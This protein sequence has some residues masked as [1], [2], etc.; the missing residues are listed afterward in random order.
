MEEEEWRQPSHSRAWPAGLS[1][2]SLVGGTGGLTG[3]LVAGWRVVGVALVVEV[4]PGGGGATSGG[5]PSL[6][7]GEEEAG[8]LEPPQLVLGH[9][10]L[11]HTDI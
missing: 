2:V 11:V 7:T 6:T 1:G 10:P 5:C 8:R 3:H 4:P 9:R